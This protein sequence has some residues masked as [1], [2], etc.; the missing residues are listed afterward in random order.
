VVRGLLGDVE[1]RGEAIDRR[2]LGRDR[3]G[4]PFR[5]A[6]ASVDEEPFE[7]ICCMVAGGQGQIGDGDAFTPPWAM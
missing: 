5:L 4:V 1:E 3:A 7:A 6:N 2:L